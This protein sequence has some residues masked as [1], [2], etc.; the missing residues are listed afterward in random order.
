MSLK[1]FDFKII[2]GPHISEK[3]S[4]VKEKTNTIIIKVLKKANKIDIK[5]VIKKI[6]NVK[7]K[8]INTLIIKGKRKKNKK[9]KFK[10]E[11]WKKA[12]ITLE[13]NQKINFNTNKKL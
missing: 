3:S 2:K 4:L 13:K 1:E 11:N 5:R 9:C 12:Y 7:I 8:N 6:F 10:K